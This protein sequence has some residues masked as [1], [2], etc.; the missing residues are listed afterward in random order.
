MD[1]SIGHGQDGSAGA[2]LQQVYC[3]LGRDW[4]RYIKLHII[5][6][7][8][9]CCDDDRVHA[10]PGKGILAV[11]QQQFLIAAPMELLVFV[12]DAAN[13]AD[14]LGKFTIPFI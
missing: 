1:L 6:I 7:I 4:Y 14:E 12:M 2:I 5:P 9:H 8:V 13:R 11:S 10:M 3:F